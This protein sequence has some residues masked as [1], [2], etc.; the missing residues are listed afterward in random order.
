[1]VEAVWKAMEVISEYGTSGKKET[2]VNP[3]RTMLF[4]RQPSIIDFTYS[5]TSSPKF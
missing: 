5:G 1:M 3:F 2:E 4:G